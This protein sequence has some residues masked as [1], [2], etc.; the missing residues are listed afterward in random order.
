M[1]IGHIHQVRRF[2]RTL[3]QRIG[4]LDGNYLDSGRPL[5]EA[6]LLFEIG[7]DGCSVRDLRA[8][9]GLD[10]GYLSR[11]LRALEAEKLISSKAADHDARIKRLRL[12]AKGKRLWATL[13]Q[14]SNDLAASLLEPLSDKHRLRLLSAMSEVE[15]LLRASSVQIGQEDPASDAAQAC[16]AAYFEELRRRFPDGFDPERSVSAREDEL[17]PPRGWFVL[18]RLEQVPIACGALKVNEPGIGEIKRMW[19]SS[20]ARGLGI[21]QRLLD[22]LET[23][24]K[25][26]GLTH[27]RLD[28]NRSLHEAQALYVRNGFQPI[29]A[30][31]DNPYA[32]FW[33][34]K[35][36]RSGDR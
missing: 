4:L 36:L 8:R 12:S 17:I 22:T 25:A 7:L 24:A 5:A 14:R 3:S 18:A 2:N 27:L 15:R 30:Y 11:M 10:S 6:R 31:N 34:Q 20:A 29:C 16:L 26:A 35:P 33:F 9:L 28:T 1:E 13:D 21:G 32:D 19:V 23:C